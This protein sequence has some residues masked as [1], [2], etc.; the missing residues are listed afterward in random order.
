MGFAGQAW[1]V[2]RGQDPQ[3]II[4]LSRPGRA[5]DPANKPRRAAHGRT[6]P[7]AVVAAVVDIIGT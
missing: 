5:T 3:L 1:S 4:A 2:F 7:V 6:T